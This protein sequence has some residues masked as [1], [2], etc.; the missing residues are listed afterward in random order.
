[1]PV[2]L[3]PVSKLLPIKGIRLAVAAAKL[4]YSG[5]PDLVLIE[6]SPNTKLAAVFTKNRYAAAPV[7]IAREHM[8]TAQTRALLIN[9]GQAN[10]GTGAPG[11]EIA[12]QSCAIVAEAL[13]CDLRRV[14]PFSTG[15]IGNA[16]PV[17]KIKIAMPSLVANLAEDGWLDAANAIMTTD[18][19][20]KG[21]SRQFTLGGKT[22]CITGI[23]KGSGMIHPNMATMLAYVG[24]DAAIAQDAL[25]TC[26]KQVTEASFGRVTVDGDTSTN[27][28]AVLL[29]TGE[30]GNAMI[31][32]VSGEDCKMFSQELLLVCT[33]LA[34][35]IIR[36]GEGATKFISVIVEQ[37]AS[38]Q[39]CVTVAQT[40]A[41][42][43]LV[44][45]AFFASDPN[46]G[47]IL[48]AVGRSPI[49]RLD[50]DKVDLYLGNVL[51]ASAGAID[52]S[53]T[54]AAGKSEMN[55]Q[56]IEI[57]VIL[58]A[59]EYS[60]TVWTCDLSHEYIRINAEYRS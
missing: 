36:D 11:I 6:C 12:R 10:A 51:V 59:G 58:N 18:T 40:I 16:P 47:R 26:W 19:V 54:E 30:A 20:A 50:I 28:A 53:Y 37:G 7:T 49:P 38:E 13:T 55:K 9:A 39:D 57:R 44:K 52:P 35:A 29:A 22:I 8:S 56:D 14:L 60:A 3:K 46:W 5:R 45:T 24:T 32:D 31:E 4:R 33:E 34:Q 42:S 15:I 41:L 48:A 17:D 1:M 25:E 43:P 2:G 21:F 23:T 27:D